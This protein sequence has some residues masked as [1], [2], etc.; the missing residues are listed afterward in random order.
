MLDKA[1]WLGMGIG[2][3]MTWIY[4]FDSTPKGNWKWCGWVLFTTSA[5]LLSMFWFGG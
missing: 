2:L 1:L 5:T 4:T 3:C